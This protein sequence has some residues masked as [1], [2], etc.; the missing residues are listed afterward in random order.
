MAKKPAIKP[1]TPVKE[2]KKLKGKPATKASKPKS[3]C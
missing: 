3:K 2:D 1:K